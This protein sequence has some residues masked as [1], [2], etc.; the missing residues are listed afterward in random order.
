M[1]SFY[2]AFGVIGLFL[3]FV[4]AENRV[5][6]Y[7]TRTSYWIYL[8]H[9]PI[10]FAILNLLSRANLSVFFLVFCTFL[11]SLALSIVSYE[12]IVRRTPL[13]KLV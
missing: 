4:G 2:L 5:W 11:L 3:H 1:A 10:V 12:V 13:L 7:L 8:V 9:L 6:S